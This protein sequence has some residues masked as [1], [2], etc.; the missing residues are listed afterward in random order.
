MS[1]PFVD[2]LL[3]WEAKEPLQRDLNLSLTCQGNSPLSWDLSPST[4][5]IPNPSKRQTPVQINI[6]GT[7][8]KYKGRKALKTQPDTSVN[9]D[10]DDK[11]L[12]LKIHIP[13]DAGFVIPPSLD[14]VV[15]HT[16]IVHT[17]LPTQGE[18]EHLLK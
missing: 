3:E 9:T 1:K 18:I 14:K 8:G 11:V 16:Q 6:Q 5:Q 12:E 2:Q 15:D 4:G 7:I 13:T 10:Y 17:I